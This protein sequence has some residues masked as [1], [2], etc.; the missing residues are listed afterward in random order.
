[1]YVLHCLDTIKEKYKLIKCKRDQ[2]LI[3]YML[4]TG[5]IFI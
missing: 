5:Y 2:D 1:M 3:G 4:P